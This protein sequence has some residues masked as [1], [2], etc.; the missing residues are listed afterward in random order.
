MTA[1]RISQGT[2]ETKANMEIYSYKRSRE[3]EL[4]WEDVAAAAKDMQ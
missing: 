1:G 3:L 4:S 2:R